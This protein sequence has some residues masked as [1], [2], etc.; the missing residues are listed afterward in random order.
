MDRRILAGVSLTVLLAAA[1]PAIAQQTISVGGS[2]SGSLQSGDSRLDS[3]AFV[4]TYQF[5]G[6]AGQ[7]VTVGLTSGDLDSYLM[8]RGPS[9]FSQENDDRD[10][11]VKD[12]QITARLPADG[13]YRISATSYEAGETGAYRLTLQS[14]GMSRA[15][16][17][18]GA[19][20]GGTARVGANAGRLDAGD[21]TLDGGE[22]IDRWT[23]AGTPGARYS[24]RLSAADFDA[25]LF[26][27]GDGLEEGN[28]DDPAGRGSRDSRLEFV[29]PADG[30][31]TLAATSYEGGERG[32]Y[33]LTIDQAGAGSGG[34][35]TVAATSGELTLGQTINGRLGQGDSTLR[36]G[37]YMNAWTLRGRAGDQVDLRLSSSAFDAYLFISGPN[38]FNAVNDDADGSDS[39][40]TV[41][42]PADGEYQVV[43]TTYE[44]G[45]SGAYRLTTARAT[46]A[47]AVAAAATTPGF[48]TGVDVRG[49]LA[50]GDATLSSGEFADSYRFSG[51]R[52]D[53]VALSLQSSDFDAYLMMRGPDGERHE[54]DDGS[55]SSTDSA[56]DMVLPADGDY[57]ITVTSYEAG[58]TGAYRFVAGPSQGTPRQAGVS[59]GPR[60]FAVMVGI[61][62][63]GGEARNLAYTADDAR[64]LAE[65]LRREGVLNPSSIVLTD[66]QATV[67]GVRAAFDQVARQ[68]GPDD[69]F[70]FFFSGHGMQRDGTVSAME[71]DG[72]IETIALRDGEISD[73]EMATMFGRL[74]T[75]L[76]MVVLDSCFSGGFARNV[77]SRPGTVGLFSSEEDLTSAVAGKFEAGGYLAHF[78]RSGLTGEANLDADD[79]ITAG[80]LSTYLR[81][82]FARDVDNVQATTLDGQRNYQNLVI[83]RGG[84]QVDD[85][86]LR[87]AAAP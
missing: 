7:T 33:T 46:G 30:Q 49:R 47:A 75:R 4:D 85:V 80:E 41:T 64:K 26:V 19:A 8:M 35:T 48:D 11:G 65:D 43:A 36:S 61:S 59:S 37:E 87:L 32:A 83:D 44:P 63:Y 62:D 14:G 79:M 10:S 15:G 76:S 1:A 54:N 34:S 39:R 57:E 67:A 24:A 69:M 78:L 73:T 66:A 82:R 23:F 52:G 27:R 55:A 53:R 38:D 40:L 22:H 5:E 21:S 68:A 3:G 25:Y 17:S 13:T 12:A 29:M 16:S 31:V 58:E 51:R 71:P 70:L 45:E 50:Q 2:V 72:R 86:V 18:S 56:I 9:G 77:V 81:R 74:N 6:R 84:V 60:V 20:G 42:L 28:D